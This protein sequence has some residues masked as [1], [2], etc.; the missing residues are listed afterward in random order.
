MK[1]HGVLRGEYWV[2]NECI[3]TFDTPVVVI[4]KGIDAIL[5]ITF[6]PSEVSKES[7]YI[8]LS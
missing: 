2:G 5:D 1:I 4:D 8:G 3:E 7:L 6:R